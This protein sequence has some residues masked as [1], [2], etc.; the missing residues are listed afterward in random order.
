MTGLGRLQEQ[1]PQPDETGKTQDEDQA[2][3]QGSTVEQLEAPQGPEGDEPHHGQL[4]EGHEEQGQRAGGNHGGAGP[5]P[6]H[7]PS[8]QHQFQGHRRRQQ[9]FQ[10]VFP[11]EGPGVHLHQDPHGFLAHEHR[12]QPGGGRAG[13]GPAGLR[14]GPAHHQHQQPQGAQT[15]EHRD[16]T[17]KPLEARSPGCV[18]KGDAGG[19]EGILPQEAEC[20]QYVQPAASRSHPSSARKEW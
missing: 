19:H 10:P 7:R 9:K 15:A 14:E 1:G 8:A 11:D 6:G 20:P 3:T 12:Q 5:Q 4:V 13:Q 17:E 18:R 16:P 2:G